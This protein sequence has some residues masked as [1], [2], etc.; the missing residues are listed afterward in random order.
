MNALTQQNWAHLVRADHVHGSLYTDPANFQAELEKI[1]YRTWVY[2]G[3]VS[4]VPEVNDFVMKS[5]GPQA[6]LMTREP[7][8]LRSVSDEC[9][10]HHRYALLVVILRRVNSRRHRIGVEAIQ[11]GRG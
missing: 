7:R 1:W 4:E 9:L 11:D 2:V 8:R 6:V 3:H 10:T 5:I